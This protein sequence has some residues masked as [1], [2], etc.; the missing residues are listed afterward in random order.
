ML[1]QSMDPSPMGEQ[2][3]TQF[4]SPQIVDI[5][6][7]ELTFFVVFILPMSV[8]PFPFDH[9]QVNWVRVPPL[10]LQIQKQCD[11]HRPLAVLPTFDLKSFSCST[12]PLLV[13]SPKSQHYTTLLSERHSLRLFSYTIEDHLH[14]AHVEIELLVWLLCMALPLC[15]PRM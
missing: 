12:F 15:V 10:S 5:H 8:N 3:S 9:Q 6:S 4:A 1:E 11:M 2:N 14:L 7:S 13:C